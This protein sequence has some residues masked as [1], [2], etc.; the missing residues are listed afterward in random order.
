[1]LSVKRTTALARAEWL[2]FRRNKTIMFMSLIFPVG[3]S[4]ATWFLMGT[5]DS[6]DKQ[7][8]GGMTIQMYMFLGL[9]MVLFY[10][11]LSM[12]TTRRDE[13]VL[14]RLRTGEARDMD[15]LTAIGIPGTIVVTALLIVVVGFLMVMGSVP[16]NPLLVVAA[17]V[18]GVLIF[19]ALAYL[20][21]SFT[22]NAEAAQMTSMPVMILTSVSL[23]NIRAML[24]DRIQELIED[25]PVASVYDLTILGWVGKD[26]ADLREVTT[27]MSF[28]DTFDAAGM[29]LVKI[30]VWFALMA[31]M[32][33]VM[34]RWD[35]HRG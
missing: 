4:I 17:L 5:D 26:T 24:P 8:L 23:D 3:M 14:K 9:F 29:P 30:V 10:S 13:G 11:M 15:I 31:W 2:Q 19:A 12:V 20:T 21:A 27:P 25:N 1:M 35:T 16:V 28:T 7:I 18:G 6:T 22:K 32:V 33:Y 34:M